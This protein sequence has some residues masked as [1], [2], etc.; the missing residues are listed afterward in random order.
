[1]IICTELIRR[2]LASNYVTFFEKLANTL[3]LLSQE[4]PQYD[5]ITE[6]WTKYKIKPTERFKLLLA[7]VYVDVF[8]FFRSVALI[9]TKKDGRECRVCPVEDHSSDFTFRAEE[10]RS[11]CY[12]TLLEAI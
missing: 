5:T 8:Q 11:H 7:S 12:R 1:M 10:K 6:I 3:E 9:F 4:L 2:K